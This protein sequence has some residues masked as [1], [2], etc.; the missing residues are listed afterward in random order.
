MLR[1]YVF[2]L[3][4]LYAQIFVE[5]HAECFNHMHSHSAHVGYGGVPYVHATAHPGPGRVPSARL[6]LSVCLSA[7]LPVCLSAVSGCEWDE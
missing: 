4:P 5:R 1:H 2:F 6:C 3:P 7:C